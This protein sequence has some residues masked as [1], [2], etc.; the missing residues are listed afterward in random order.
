MGGIV[1]SEAGPHGPQRRN[2]LA[3]KSNNNKHSNNHNS[4]DINAPN[5]DSNNSTHGTWSKAT[6]S[7]QASFDSFS[8]HL[9]LSHSHSSHGLPGNSSSHGNN[10]TSSSGGSYGR[11]PEDMTEA[12]FVDKFV[13]FIGRRL[14]LDESRRQFVKRMSTSLYEL[15]TGQLTGSTHQHE[16]LCGMKGM[17]KTALVQEFLAA[18]KEIIPNYAHFV[19]IDP[20]YY[21]TGGTSKQNLLPSAAICEHLNITEP[22]NIS[23][24][25]NYLFER[26]IRIC[27]AID[28][29]TLVYQTNPEIGCQFLSEVDFIGA[30]LYGVFQCVIT[31][32]SAVLSVLVSGRL[33]SSLLDS[34]PSY[35]AEDAMHYKFAQWRKHTLLPF[36]TRTDFVG[37]VR[38]LEENYNISFRGT[39]DA[40]LCK[41]YME[42]AGVPRD[43]GFR[44]RSYPELMHSQNN[45]MQELQ[46]YGHMILHSNASHLR[47]LN[48]IVA[49]ISRNSSFYTPRGAAP[50]GTMI[51]RNCSTV[52]SEEDDTC[53]H[54]VPAVGTHPAFT[55]GSTMSRTSAG[56]T[57]GTLLEV[58]SMGS[59]DNIDNSHSNSNNNNNGANGAAAAAN[60][61]SEFG[62]TAPVTVSE[63][64]AT[65]S[66][67][68]SGPGNLLGDGNG[69]S[70]SPG[71][72]LDELRDM[73]DKGLIYFHPTSNFQR[74]G[75]FSPLLYLLVLSDM[76]STDFP[77]G[78]NSLL[79]VEELACV[80]NAPS[81][82]YE[83]MRNAVV[84]KLLANCSAFWKAVGCKHCPKQLASLIASPAKKGARQNKTHHNGQEHGHAH[85]HTHGADH[86]QDAND[87]H[88]AVGPDVADLMKILFRF[89]RQ[90][91]YIERRP[92]SVVSPGKNDTSS[93]HP[94][95][96]YRPSHDEEKAMDEDHV[97][98]EGDVGLYLLISSERARLSEDAA[99]AVIEAFHKLPS[100]GHAIAAATSPARPAAAAAA[101]AAHGVRDSRGSPVD[102][103]SLSVSSHSSGSSGSGSGSGK[104]AAMVARPKYCL[105]T[106]YDVPPP[107]RL[108]LESA[109]IRVLAGPELCAVGLWPRAVAALSREFVS[110]YPYP[111]TATNM[112]SFS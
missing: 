4:P 6:A 74:I 33:V 49:I 64:T 97:Y 31:D 18:G 102:P 98:T 22:M 76:H 67:D 3:R 51:E 63:V 110:H 28:R 53:N 19:A 111:Y 59:N 101:A 94:A 82:H 26:R 32:V 103:S 55:S 8:D 60:A 52:L 80:Y 93:P 41:L 24:L 45:T 68:A 34:Y 37:L 62:W 50:D 29:F 105:L 95:D 88:Q 99:R 91:C 10:G 81:R 84:L 72:S 75:L 86:Q 38:K 58:G 46:A 85:E 7:L 57:I 44:L 90:L 66:Q 39:S 16:L 109:G 47:I 1:S 73:Q 13:K 92:S 100:W 25:S 11:R 112:L 69:G 12:V 104:I 108:G 5:K 21:F 107:L 87:A 89:N 43:L 15:T 20:Y 27:I 61:M 9:H 78:Y 65:W 70:S 17:G 56:N 79:T 83:K 2:D 23:Q 36:H 54:G 14:C 30:N 35:N 106:T 77:Q 40:D 48:R 96:K 42:S 71:A